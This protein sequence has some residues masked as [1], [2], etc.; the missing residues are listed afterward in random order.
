MHQRTT[1]FPLFDPRHYGCSGWKYRGLSV[2]T[3]TVK[4]SR[5][6]VESVLLSAIQR[7]LFTKEG[8]ALFTQE[9]TRLL[10]EHRRTQKPDLL[11]AKTR[12]QD[13]EREIENIM[14][15]IKA[16]ILTSSTK[17]AL[18]RTEAERATLLQTVQGQHKHL[19]KV[20]DFLP[21][22]IGRFKTLIDDLTNVTQ[23]Q[24]DRARGLL[25]V[26]LGNAIVLHPMADGA[27]RYLTAEVTGDY[28]GLLRLA[29]GQNK[30]GGGQ[31]N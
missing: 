19:A 17:A 7:D 21:N 3:N 11:H 31:G 23:L 26:L 27:A 29:T 14:V 10:T 2:C 13:V 8:L 6:I 12:L 4:A 15:A 5:A 16:G 9:A 18:E 24:V 30:G 20:A 22:A 28:A 25:R 1:S